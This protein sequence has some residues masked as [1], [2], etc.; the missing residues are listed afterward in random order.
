MAII[1][2]VYRAWDAR[3]LTLESEESPN[4][5]GA[6]LKNLEYVFNLRTN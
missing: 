6:A 1:A 2:E 5:V 4:R 3:E